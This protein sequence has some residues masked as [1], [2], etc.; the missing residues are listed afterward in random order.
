MIRVT[1]EP[2][3]L[4]FFRNATRSSTVFLSSARWNAS[5]GA[6]IFANHFLLPRFSASP[7]FLLSFLSAS[8]WLFTEV[9]F[10]VRHLP[11]CAVVF[12]RGDALLETTKIIEALTR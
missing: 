12:W 8:L 7:I 4:T 5:L 9:F 6:K 3:F 2:P 11:V 10:I 1:R